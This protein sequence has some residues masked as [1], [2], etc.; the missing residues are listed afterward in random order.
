MV[1]NS[2]PDVSEK[3]YTSSLEIHSK[4]VSELRLL[5][6]Y[7]RTVS[8]TYDRPNNHHMFIDKQRSTSV[9]DRYL[10]PRYTLPDET[11]ESTYFLVEIAKLNQMCWKVRLMRCD[12]NWSDPLMY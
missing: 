1:D 6:K 7:R 10:G 2:P 8:L 9:D 4:Y 3:T 12:A 5:E 11:L